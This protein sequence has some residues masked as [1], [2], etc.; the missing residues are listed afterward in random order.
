MGLQS[1]T[2]CPVPHAPGQ[3][4][5]CKARQAVTFSMRDPPAHAIT[6]QTPAHAGI[7]RR[8]CCLLV[9]SVAGPGV[10]GWPAES[11]AAH[12]HWHTSLR[13]CAAAPGP[14]ARRTAVRC[15][16]GREGAGA[17]RRD[18]S[19]GRRVRAA[20]PGRERD[21][22]LSG[23]RA[24]ARGPVPLVVMLHGAGG[25]A[26][27]IRRRLFGASDSLDFAL[28]IPDSRG[29]TWD[30]IRGMYGPDIAFLDSALRIVFSRVSI[31]PSRVIV[32]GFSY[33]AS[34]ALAIGRKRS[35][36]HTSALQA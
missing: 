10:A 14:R 19:G 33:G 30:A 12:G 29:P 3:P 31:D 25:S 6:P 11:Q 23:P 8:H 20:R 35:A 9:R 27:G 28:L 36:G 7:C 32:S 24:A 1:Q 5:P 4:T 22:L 15:A 26:Q 21:G 13:L 18:A 34:Y 16:R 2:P 17:A